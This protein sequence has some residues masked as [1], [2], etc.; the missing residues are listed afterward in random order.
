MCDNGCK[1]TVKKKGNL[2]VGELRLALLGSPQIFVNGEEKILRE[3][4]AIAF[5]AWLALERGAQS[6]DT[7]AT[8]FWPEHDQQR[9][10]ANLRYLLWSLRKELGA[11]WL[12]TEG[13]Q[14]ALAGEDA[15]W[16]DV[17]E[18]QQQLAE[19]RAHSHPADEFCADCTTSLEA[20]F[21]LYRG[22]FLQGF[23]LDDSSQFDDW[24]FFQAEEL[25]RNLAGAL[26]ALVEQE[27]TRQGYDAAID[28]ARRWLAL[29]PLHEPATR[30]LMKLYAWTDQYEAAIRQFHRCALALQEEIGVEPDVETSELYALIRNRRFPSPVG[31]INSTPSDEPQPIPVVAKPVGNL[32]PPTTAFVGREAELAQIAAH[33]ADPSM[34]LLTVV[35]PGG[36]GKSSLALQAGSAEAGRFPDGVWFVSLAELESSEQVPAAILNVLGV[37]SG[38]SSARQHLLRYLHGKQCLLILDNFEDVLPAAEFVAE[39]LPACPQVNLLVTTRERLNLHEE[40]LLILGRL[41]FPTDKEKRTDATALA[42]FSA[43][44]LFALCAQR[45]QPGFELNQVSLPPVI[46]ICQLVDGMPLALEMAAGWIRVLPVVQIPAEIEKSLEF[47]ATPTR[48]VV[49]RHRSIHAVFDS[50]WQL[51]PERERSLLRQLS[52]FRNG[53]SREGAE[54]VAGASLLELSALLDKSWI[55]LTSDGRYRMHALAQQYAL[56]K[57]HSGT[58]ETVGDVLQHHSLFYA[59]MAPSNGRFS[60]DDAGLSAAEVE[61]LRLAWETALMQRN[62]TALRQIDESNYVMRDGRGIPG[63]LPYMERTITQMNAILESLPPD[64]EEERVAVE[65]VLVKIMQ[66]A[67]ENQIDLSDTKRAIPRLPRSRSLLESRQSND[68]PANIAYAHLSSTLGFAFYATGQFAKA[69][70]FFQ[71]ALTAYQT[72]EHQPGMANMYMYL[73]MAYDRQGR[74]S[75]AE[76]VMHL[77]G[78]VLDRFHCN[79][80][81]SRSLG[82]VLTKQGRYTESR[83]ILE[84]ALIVTGYEYQSHALLFLGSAVRG[85]GEWAEAMEIL[86]KGLAIADETGDLPAQADLLLE[87]GLTTVQT[88]ESKVAHDYF[89]RSLTI[90]REIGRQRTVPVALMGLGQ[91]EILGRHLAN[92]R[93]YLAQALRA[94]EEVQAPPDMLDILVSVGELYAA[95]GKLEAA[96]ELLVLAC[97][98]PATTHETRTRSQQML[99]LLGVEPPALDAPPSWEA[100]QM[101]LD[102]SVRATQR[103]LDRD[104]TPSP[105]APA[106]I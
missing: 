66:I 64:E 87:L 94:E 25:R 22:D 47:L 97:Q 3:R 83:S 95:E 92:A 55:R 90:A 45:L 14:I 37:S 18:F 27:M 84:E 17:A 41:D 50:S 35:G 1:W 20:A 61:N 15:V 16:V 69:E 10:R 106:G 77:A 48:N 56:E 63:L 88:G 67:G 31:N 85:Q 104:S 53:F 21:A 13:D 71:E 60:D 76:E 8:L 28:H 34:R 43:L 82:R 73:A 6:R 39:L 44:Q 5:L 89:T 59:A 58:V 79:D 12:S 7:L 9:A 93:D 36:M 98:H 29:D 62:W 68:H 33:L 65:T 72:I 99:N 2:L 80:V 26:E 70:A 101:R 54:A 40:W 42:Q 100:A 74:Y 46:R 23:S 81:M 52:V 105:V 51:L 38:G 32:P 30:A 24:Q 91:A 57:L 86:K 19:W 49:E 96:S 11:E 4:K 102:E 103:E 75:D 78:R